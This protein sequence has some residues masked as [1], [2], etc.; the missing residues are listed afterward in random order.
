MDTLGTAL[1]CAFTRWSPGL[2]DNNVVGWVTVL[3]Y[4]AAALASGRMARALSRA[5]PDGGERRFWWIACAVLMVLAINKQLDLQSLLTMLARCHA[6]LSGW[7]DMRRGVQRLFILAV[8]GGAALLVGALA[9]L[10]RG[11]LARVW[12]ALLGLAF[13][14]CFVVIR[15]ASFHNVDGLLGWTALGVKMNWLL[16]LTGPGLVLSVALL[17]HRKVVST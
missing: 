8:A 15:A 14:C 4:L 11:A 2:G 7:Y 16:E 3:V 6:S 5:V 1:T 10:L 9:V 17:R 12:P 13:V